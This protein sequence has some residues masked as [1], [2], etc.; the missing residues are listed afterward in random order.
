[1]NNM[2]SDPWQISQVEF[3]QYEIQFIAQRPVDG[4]LTGDQ[5]REFFMKSGL[6]PHVLGQIWNLADIT[7]DGKLD[8]LEFA[9]AMKLIRNVLS[10]IPLP[11]L[12]PEQMKVISQPLPVPVMRPPAYGM[13]QMMPPP[14]YQHPG[15]LPQQIQSRRQSFVL[16]SK[17]LCDWTIPQNLKLQYAQQFNQLDKARADY[18]TGQQLRGVMGE[19]QLPSEILAQIWNYADFNK[20]GYLSIERFCVA[21]FLIDK[22]KDG[23]ALPK[24]L[25]PELHPHHPR[26]QTESPIVQ[27]PGALPPQKSPAPKTFEDKR[28]EN[29]SKGEQEL[30]R[31]REVLRKEEED[32]RR[33]EFE[34]QERL[35]LEREAAEKLAREK[36][37]AEAEL[38]R[39]KQRELEEQNAAEEAKLRAEREKQQIAAEEA[40]LKALEGRHIADLENQLQVEKEKTAQI[41]QR[42]N[43][44]IFQLQ[45]L[46]E[47]AQQL[48]TE[49]GAA[50]D[51]IME[52]TTEIEGMR[53][54]RDDKIARIQQLQA[55]SQ[56]IAVQTERVSHI[57]LQLQSESQKS[58]SRG[59]EIEA[60]RATIEQR[61]TQILSTE[62]AISDAKQ[63]F[64]NQEKLI[65][66]K[67]P[68][69]EEGQEKLKKL[70]DVYNE[71]LKKFV[72]RQ[73][74]L[75]KK[76]ME[77][78][79]Q[80]QKSSLPAG[81]LYEL[82]PDTNGELNSTTQFSQS[83][84][85]NDS[86]TPNSGITN[87]S[88]CSQSADAINFT[89]S[90]NSTI[91]AA[92][93]ATGKPPVKYRALYVFTARSEDELSLQPGDTILVFEDH[94]A[95]AG[96]LAGQ[97]REKVGWFPA[98]FAEPIV[99]KKPTTKQPSLT[100]SPSTE[101]LESIKEE[102]TEKELTADLANM[103]LKSSTSVN[104]LKKEIVSNGHVQTPTDLQPMASL[105]IYDAPPGD[106]PTHK[107]SIQ[108]TTTVTTTESKEGDGSNSVIAVGVAA[109]AWKARNENE[110][111]FARGD[112]IEILEQKEMR[113]RGRIAG[114]ADGTVGW[115][116][117]SY[118]KLTDETS[119]TN[120]TS[121]DKQ[122]N[123]TAAESGE[124]FIAVFKFDAVEPTD[125]SL[126]PGDRIWVTEKNGEW[127]N[128]TV[129]GR[130][131]IF[132]STYAQA[133]DTL[134]QS[135]TTGSLAAVAQSPVEGSLSAQ[136]SVEST[137]N[138]SRRVSAASAS[139][140]H[141]V[142]GEWF[143]ALYQF[144]AVEPTDL[145]I[146]IGDRIWVTG[147]NGDWWNG[148][149]DGRSGIFPSN[150][151]EKAPQLTSTENASTSVNT[152][153][154]NNLRKQIIQELIETEL[155]FSE[156]MLFVR[157]TFMKPFVRVIG[158]TG[159][160]QVFLNWDS[161]IKI[162][163]RLHSDLLKHT[164][165][166]VFCRRIDILE[167]FVQFCESQQTSISFLNEL[168]R[169][170]PKF[171]KVYEQCMQ[172][173]KTMSLHYYLLLPMTRITRL[174]LIIERLIK[175]TPIE[176]PEYE[177][178]T[179]AHQL[180]RSLLERVNEGI[181]DFE[182]KS[183]L[184]WCQQNVRCEDLPNLEFTSETREV[185]S[186]EYL[187]SGILYKK[188]N[189]MLVALCFNDFLLL[190]IPN[191]PIDNVDS[192]KVTTELHH[193]KLTM[194]KKPFMFNS[195]EIVSTIFGS[196]SPAQDTSFMLK[197][198]NNQV[199]LRAI[200]RNSKSFWINQL[201]KAI[202]QY[203][204][205]S[206][207]R[208]VE[209]RPKNL[210]NTKEI[211]RLLVEILSVTSPLSTVS[212]L[213]LKLR[214]EPSIEKEVENEVTV[215]DGQSIYTTQIPLHSLEQTFHLSFNVPM[216]YRPDI[217]VGKTEES[218]KNI[219]RLRGSHP[220]PII[221][222]LKLNDGE[223]SNYQNC[224]VNDCA[225]VTSITPIT[226]FNCISHLSLTKRDLSVY[227]YG[228]M[229]TAIEVDYKRRLAV[230]VS[231]LIY[232]AVVSL[233]LTALA[234]DYWFVTTTLNRN[235]QSVGASSNV[236]SGLF[237]G[238]RQLDFGMG[239]RW[240]SFSVLE[241]IQQDMSLVDKTTW[242]FTVFFIALGL[243]WT[244]VGLLVSI[245][246]S[247][248]A[249]TKT[250][251]G[252]SG[253][254]VWSSLA[255]LSFIFA[256][257][258]YARQLYGEFSSKYST[259]FGISFWI[260]NIGTILLIVPCVLV[261]LTNKSKKSKEENEVDNSIL[262]Y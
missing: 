14:A 60:L 50:R 246:S 187:H 101:P 159:I 19:S 243:L 203:D 53:K 47:K 244:F 2:A 117:K 35:K 58:L 16:G 242:I 70:A 180:L 64:A 157:N 191:S 132:P 210:S 142:G 190:T 178:L 89:P 205:I 112:K 76:V 79:Q 73:Q 86:F 189:K 63:R 94:N 34:R 171:R 192:F 196:S 161:L 129:N 95:E 69:Y 219:M 183:I 93:T 57:N 155:R 148:T 111:N 144:D 104:S 56:E 234:T 193:L 182:N 110:L 176:D 78:R 154:T 44:M 163:K 6:Q 215:R 134:K 174:P 156:E 228:E 136:K 186:R 62:T 240:Y 175:L 197:D 59:R 97:I 48:N 166:Q 113:W 253:L 46:D 207:L 127:W 21:M 150:Y 51:E 152:T 249:Q 236:H 83:A 162:S 194:Y 138:D 32:R 118:V 214:L 68:A 256:S 116:P 241:E 36:A 41:K 88:N 201:Q 67:R 18:L 37:E 230:F 20:D 168:E 55:Q 75:H 211:G 66:E 100:T 125:L 71:L 206:Q 143:V 216:Q 7:H 81:E 179:D 137:T 13:P 220:G 217:C 12:L 106:T 74:E 17:E 200:S 153:S 233:V 221:R 252:P 208:K 131:G 114:K 239:P 248:I 85:F 45:G 229:G 259:R 232:I 42:H 109:F 22:V 23:Y 262:V 11:T 122:V 54:Q 9:I 160:Q 255:F 99:A 105:P 177:R 167:A 170:N 218:M 185:G 141:E 261:S 224:E 38:Q 149:V 25:P 115:F 91:S 195:L 102:P 49:I 52:I 119:A 15:M 80:E 188:S 260:F 164:P 184:C 31:R 238:Q 126:V 27:E 213:R 1:M 198:A 169:S 231:L 222:M 29:L 30:Q 165:G 92:P 128:G 199:Q 103:N 5:T 172:Q 258:L 61:K 135:S 107:P 87:F 235:G 90:T 120:T 24:T 96:W 151:V 43:T 237:H 10:N 147:K 39:Q 209:N 4:F 226:C 124:W 8:R 77:K 65:A 72:S 130:S 3:Q 158:E 223:I 202:D 225:L 26:S 257:T 245:L 84:G 139:V 140:G 212:N 227:V 204:V 146:K 28:L 82:P 145:S 40:R 173:A 123:P 181:K 254:I 108:S 247:V 251:T 250:I 33:I 98:S 121:A 133:E